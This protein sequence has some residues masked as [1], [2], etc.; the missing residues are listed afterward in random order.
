MESNTLNSIGLIFDIIGVLMLFKYGLPND[1]NPK[2]YVY[3]AFEETD[4]EGIKKY[5]HYKS[6]SYLAL[7]IILIGFTLQ[8][9]S[10]H[11]CLLSMFF[12]LFDK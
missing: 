10:N 1:L 2:G 4:H 11:E 8:I 7:S 3:M 5:K 12:K 9:F 6:M